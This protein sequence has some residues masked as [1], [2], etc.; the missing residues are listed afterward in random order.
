MNPIDSTLIYTLGQ[1]NKGA[2]FGLIFVIVFLVILI[3]FS[4]VEGYTKENKK[5]VKELEGGG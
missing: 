2:I 1:A 5:Q 3:G 4:L